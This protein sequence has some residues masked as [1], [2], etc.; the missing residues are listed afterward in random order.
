MYNK[1]LISF[2]IPT[3]NRAEILSECLFDLIDKI[4]CY[5]FEIIVSDNCSDDHTEE[6]VKEFQSKYKNLRYL[7]QSSRIGVDENFSV[8]LSSSISE[9]TWLIGDSY[10]IEQNEI[11]SLL[12]LMKEKNFDL[13]ILN[14]SNQ[15]K[16]LE[17]RIYT[18]LSEFFHDLGWYLPMMSAYIYSAEILHNAHYEKF[19]NSNFLQMGITFEYLENREFEIYWHAKN[20]FGAT[21]LPKI[22]WHNEAFKVFAKNWTEF[23][24]SLP[25]SIDLPVKLDCIKKHGV[26]YGVFSFNSL[27]L[28]R[29]KGYLS[30]YHYR[31]YKLYFKYVN[32]PPPFVIILISILPK[33]LL[34]NLWD[35]KKYL[36]K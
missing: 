13:L 19:F 11:E 22:S 6:I 16:N 7:K 21:T 14:S 2:C 27:L 35:F 25:R 34:T 18:D 17:S 29:K 26:N 36:T 28:L 9:Y 5:D 24:L 32:I 3:C 30:Y 12:S 10:R 31:T 4:G 33:N 15:V 8:A 20:G 23:V 1:K